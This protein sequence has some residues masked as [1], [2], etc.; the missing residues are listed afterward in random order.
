VRH[1]LTTRFTLVV[2]VV[3]V[4]ASLLWALLAGA[5]A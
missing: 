5:V 4:V 1:Q 2:S 3:L